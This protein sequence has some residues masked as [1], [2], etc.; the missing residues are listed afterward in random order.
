M[1]LE[2]KTAV[3]I[4]ASGTDNF[5]VAI[6][7]KLAENG[8]TVVVSGRRIEPLRKLASELQ[9][10]AVAC[11]ISDE[12]QVKGLF[13]TA[14]SETGS[15]DIAVN[16]AGGLAAAPISMLTKEL[17]QPTLD[18]SFT[19]AL[20]FM[21]YAAEHMDTG[22]SVM[23]ISSLTARLPGPALAVY[24]AARS[25]IDFAIRIAAVEY[26]AQNI[27]FNSIAAG[28]IHTDMTAAMFQDDSTN[29][30]FIPHIPLARMGNTNDIAETA[31]WL[32]DDE[33][34]PFITGQL[35]DVS[36]GQHMGRLPQ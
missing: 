34:S 14:H 6:A 25:G 16:C 13:E 4:G 29:Q 23:T 3:V 7:R 27:R 2:H 22:G 19:G 32:A 10:V 5:G 18:V 17:I 11:D 21:R 15:V 20:L 28:L 31:L 24:A 30:R 8:C 36:G 9:G 35:I 33:K 12:A 1:S 26:G